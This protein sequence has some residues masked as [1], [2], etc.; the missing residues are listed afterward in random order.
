MRRALAVVAAAAMVLGSLALRDRLDRREEERTTVLRLVCATELGPVCERLADA[1]DTPLDLTVEAAGTTADRL[2]A[3]ESDPELD[4]WLVSAPWP[5]M[6]D[7][8]RRARALPPLFGPSGAPLARSPLV[9]VVWN[10]RAAVLATRCEGGQV[11]WSCLGDAAG[12]AGGWAA[13]GG[14][15]EW[16]PVKP[17]HGDAVTDDV[18]LLVL[19]QAVAAFLGRTDLSTADLDDGRFERWFAALER[20]VPPS[21]RSPLGTMLVTGPAAYDAVGTTEAEA[22]PLLERSV[23]GRDLSLLYPSPMATADVVLATPEGSL[24]RRIRQVASG[25]SARRA[26]A[27]AGFRVEG[28][29]APA[30]GPPLPPTSGLPSPGLLDAVRSRARE[31]TGR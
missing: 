1:G 13:I 16:G 21:P 28:V 25:D 4:G 31:V 8:A 24:G 9:L 18:G 11:G 14:R 5:E 29:R 30:G 27:D 20:A 26:L 15:P 2:T 10:D 7:G 17:G 19:G 6:V 12:A 22:R 23:R 3:V